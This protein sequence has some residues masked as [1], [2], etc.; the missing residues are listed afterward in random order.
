MRAILIVDDDPD[1]LALTQH[2][3]AKAGVKAR[4]D[5]VTGRR[6]AIGYLKQRLARGESALPLLT[7]L[8][9]AMP[10]TDGFAVLQWIRHQPRLRR[11][12]RVVMSSSLRAS[13]LPGRGS[14]CAKKGVRTVFQLANAVLSIDEIEALVLPSLS[15]RAAVL[16]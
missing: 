15:P 10:G 12:L 13:A 2:A 1:A 3:L 8:D 4:L 6:R 16:R 11:L 9:L 5:V 14:S 7:F